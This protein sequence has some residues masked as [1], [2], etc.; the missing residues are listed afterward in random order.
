MAN[1]ILINPY[2]EYAKGINS[3]TVTPP[4][5]LAYLAGV[6][7]KN[8]H[9]VQ[10]VDAQILGITPEKIAAN[11]LFRPELIG[12]SVN[13]ITYKGAV[14]CANHLK[15][16]YPDTPIVFGG[17]YSSSLAGN[18]L[19]KV[20]AVDAVVIG[21]G[22]STLTEIAGAIGKA[23]IFSNIDGVA[24]KHQGQ[25]IRNGPRPLIKNL[26]DI[27]FPAYHLLP[28]L[29]I[30]K[31]RTRGWPLGYLITSRG[32]PVQCTFCNRS[33]F[34]TSWRPHSVSRVVEEISYLV[35][36]YKVRQIDI[37]DDNFTF[38]T[39]RAE[40]ILDRLAAAPFKI[41]LNLQNGVKIDRMSDNL[42]VKMKRAGVFKIGFGIETAAQDIQKKVKK[43]I[44][45]KKAAA[46]IKTARSLGIVT[47][48]FF[49][50]GLPG[51]NARTMQETIA[52]LLKANPHF[53]N[54]SICTP[55]PG[56]ELFEE[57]KK[58]GFFLEDIENGLDSGFFG[59]KPFF[60]L[61]SMDP[62]EVIS[63]FKM[64]Y[65]KFYL[66]PAKMID[67]LFTIRSFRELGWLMQAARDI[68][69]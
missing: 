14:K 69:V 39:R 22:E 4:L 5:G 30:Y 61:G 60:R 67:V 23:D 24:Y 37:L 10:I 36:R 9:R 40:E 11:F 42:L 44:D 31:A 63:Y 43:P 50:I 41:Y 68:L 17:P 29:R 57:I 32:C 13:I 48:G 27:P 35:N 47:I 7:E 59:S 12:I 55:F 46:L 38:D 2:P 65:N 1:I 34:G 45:L 16:L 52:F 53:A 51:D 25:I 54:I 62:Q 15:S 18:I 8:K 66:R 26:D 6:L 33:I 58:E 21:E 56:T 3:A 28:D 64:A 20:P 19:E 49:M